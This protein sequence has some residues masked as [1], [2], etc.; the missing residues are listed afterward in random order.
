MVLSRQVRTLLMRPG[1]A[2][3]LYQTP[4]KLLAEDFWNINPDATDA[5]FDPS[6]PD[7]EDL[8]PLSLTTG[9]HHAEATRQMLGRWAEDFG[10][11]LW[12]G[13]SFLPLSTGE[14]RGLGLPTPSHVQGGPWI[15]T[16]AGSA[17]NAFA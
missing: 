16:V 9:Y 4:T 17:T 13:R 10:K 1:S 2:I 15:K 14:G 8:D 5:S 11:P 7:L 3:Y 12:R 6:P